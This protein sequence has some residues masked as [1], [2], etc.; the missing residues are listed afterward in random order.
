MGADACAGL[1]RQVDGDDAG[2][3]E[4][5]GAAHQLFCQLAA[6]LTDSHGTQSAVAGVG[7]GAEDH[8][9]AACHGLAVVAV[10]VGH[11]GGHVDAAVLVGRRQRELVVVLV[12]GAA[13]GAQ[14]VVA[15]GQDVRQR[16]L[17]HAGS[18]GSLDDADIGDIVAGHG[19]ELQAQVVHVIALVVGFQDAVSHS[20][21]GGLF[22]RG[23]DAG[24][25]SDFFR[26][27]TDGFTVHEVDAVVIQFD[28]KCASFLYSLLWPSTAVGLSSGL[29]IPPYNYSV[30]Y[31]FFIKFY[32]KNGWNS[33]MKSG[34]CSSR[35][36]G[37]YG[38]DRRRGYPVTCGCRGCRP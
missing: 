2:T 23:G 35:F 11:V 32:A 36:P 27:G 13:D 4:I 5:V 18:A 7:V 30:K 12:D 17:L 15:V 38:R 37:R 26:A 10:D 3:G 20:A 31:L 1:A 29:M 25:L 14:A 21:L 19:V 6:A 34:C 28:H 33:K 8:L 9:A 16:E 24:L 22:F